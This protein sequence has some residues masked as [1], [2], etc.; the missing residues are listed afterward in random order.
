[1]AL[2]DDQAPPSQLAPERAYALR[3]EIKARLRVQEDMRP[4]L[5][6]PPSFDVP[7]IL[8]HYTTA[9][10][11]LGILGEQA[12]WAT[13]CEFLNDSSEVSYGLRLADS[14]LKE[15]ILNGESRQALR[16][17]ILAD[18]MRFRPG[19]KPFAIC[20]CKRGDL[21][22]QWHGYAG[23]A[24]Y[25][26]GLSGAGVAAATSDTNTVLCPIEYEENRQR[27]IIVAQFEAAAIA[28]EEVTSDCQSPEE[29]G[30]VICTMSS[31]MLHR[32]AILAS[33]FKDPVFRGEEEWRVVR[34]C[35]WDQHGEDVQFRVRDAVIVPYLSVKL[36]N[37]QTG[38]L[39]IVQVVLGPTVDE[40]L[41][42]RSI[43]TL[44]K[45]RRSDAEVRF[46][47]IPL[48]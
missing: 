12:L 48:R 29:T 13:D 20:F 24:G 40:R 21:L 41:G 23:G 7:P 15:L 5:A 8:Y 1:M 34:H 32:A 33:M 25:A 16:K 30:I 10:G 28:V 39:P 2:M 4:E 46:S 6:W 19:I 43:Q 27:E 18:R 36:R 37:P 26:I 11:L 22:S 35:S 45:H 9:A 47:Q 42:R 44:L 3:A 14:T 17:Q 38:L 31:L